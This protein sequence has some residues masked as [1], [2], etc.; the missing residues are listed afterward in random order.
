M[1]LNSNKIVNSKSIGIL[2]FQKIENYGA[3]LQCYALWYYLKKQGYNVEIIDLLTPEHKRYIKSNKAVR[4]NKNR[5][6]ILAL[7]KTCY[8]KILQLI[9]YLSHHHDLAM[10]KKRFKEFYSLAFYSKQYSGFDEIL[11][12][13]PL[14]D[15]YITG[16]DQTWNPNICFDWE[17]YFLTFAPK[18][19]RKIAYAP[20]IALREIP[21]E[22]KDHMKSWLA[23]YSAISCREQSGVEIIKKLTSMNV[24]HVADPTFLLTREQ[25]TKLAI[26]PS[27]KTK[28]YILCLWFCAGADLQA[29]LAFSKKLKKVSGKQVV[30]LPTPGYS[31]PHVSELE[32]VFNS[33]PKEFIG[34]IANADMVLTNSFHGTAFAA[35]LATS[36]YV[37]LRNDAIDDRMISLMKILKMED[38]IISS[39]TSI[40]ITEI[41]RCAPID[42]KKLDDYL[43]NF[44]NKSIHFLLQALEGN[45]PSE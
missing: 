38:H 2:T 24:E 30:I 9:F 1:I 35:F 12:N 37:F 18:N 41:A 14:Y 31:F 15:I 4:I 23:E 19:S 13:P 6:K 40:D 42:R 45:T 27:N 36:F 7:V 11:D 44:R 33:G 20:S 16:S 32:I 25:W 10:R 8:R 28:S 5:N 39:Q 29:K 22:L 34:L 43:S 17:A 3:A 26:L 21:E